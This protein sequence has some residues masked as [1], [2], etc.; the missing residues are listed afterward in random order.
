MLALVFPGQGSQEVGM[1]RDVYDASPAARSVFEAANE[2][3]GFDLSKLCFE[4][5]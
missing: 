5:P 1:G 2:A 4:G 3:L